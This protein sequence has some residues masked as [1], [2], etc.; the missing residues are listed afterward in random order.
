MLISIILLV[1]IAFKSSLELRFLLLVTSA[2]WFLNFILHPALTL[3]SSSSGVATIA[4][5]SRLSANLFLARDALQAAVIGCLIFLTSVAI[6]TK[7]PRRKR[8]YTLNN[9]SVSP[10]HML[11]ILA[12]IGSIALFIEQTTF[13]NIFSKS[14]VSLA[15]INFSVFLW[16][17]KDI[18]IPF[19]AECFLTLVG[20]G[21][22]FVLYSRTNYSKGVILTPILIFIYRLEIWN[23]KRNRISR[24]IFFVILILSFGYLFNL[25][26]AFKLGET[27][28]TA[29][30]VGS[31][32][33]PAFLLVLLPIAQ[34]FDQFPRIID[35]QLSTD[36]NFHGFSSWLNEIWK[37]FSWNPGS[38]RVDSTFGQIWN[39]QITGQSVPSAK[40]SN[41]SLAQGF[42]SD[43]ILWN[44]YFSLIIESFIFAFLY[45]A[46][47]RQLTGNLRSIYLVFSLISNGALFESGSVAL[48]ALL[49]N[50]LKIFLTIMTIE[51][52][53]KKDNRNKPIFNNR[54]VPDKHRE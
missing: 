30:T 49:S 16:I 8:I 29:A 1:I 28:S 6:L 7:V 50:T 36:A 9:H 18:V 39:I 31:T 52:F 46:L 12:I 19:K 2:Y 15:S 25:L 13:A 10:T 38:G 41:V 35:A 4:S 40:F 14:L 43:G 22:L 48:V 53:L 47:S 32:Q 17:R 54:I 11:V 42:V 44:G 45:I 3:L 21:D 37:S 23:L 51:Y 5:D 27:F 24:F 33:F 20:F 34:R 26:Q